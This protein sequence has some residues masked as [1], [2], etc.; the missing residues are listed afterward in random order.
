MYRNYDVLVFCNTCCCLYSV[1][2]S[3]G[4]GLA[5]SSTLPAVIFASRPRPTNYW[6]WWPVGQELQE[7][8][9]RPQNNDVVVNGW[10]MS[11]MKMY[12]ERAKIVVLNVI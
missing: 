3:H 9:V 6:L 10:A 4:L 12:G 8:E 5:T 7:E 11:G 2:Y 1:Y